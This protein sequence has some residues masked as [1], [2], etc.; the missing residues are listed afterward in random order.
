MVAV[1][2]AGAAGPAL[3]GCSGTHSALDPAGPSAQAIATLWWIMLAGGGT[4]FAAA[5]AALVLA[6]TRPRIFGGRPAGVLVLW[7]GLVLPSVI[8]AMLVFSAFALGERLIG[9]SGSPP[10]RIEVEGRQWNWAFRY[11]MA[12]DL[13]TLDTL[14]IPAGREVEFL[15]TSTDV[16]HS[17]WV[18][19]LGGKIDA[20]PG[21]TNRIR[22]TA[23]EP[24][25][26]GGVC[27][28]FC[29]VGHG[30][31]RFTVVVHPAADYDEALARI[32]AE[33]GP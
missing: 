8:L 6:W 30:P 15:V 3:S 5:S 32:A 7:G 19:R 25:R 1:T 17:F 9:A 29:G 26:Y 4:I 11:P 24:G 12:G 20:L 10:L 21:K 16:I 28:E 27:A 31:M 23:D 14:H 33:G 18:P 2:V 13:K 22:L